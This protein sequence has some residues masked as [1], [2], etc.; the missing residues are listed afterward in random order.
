[1]AVCLRTGMGATGNTA[2]FPTVV[3]HWPRVEAILAQARNT[4]L[5]SRVVRAPH[6]KLSLLCTHSFPCTRTRV[7]LRGV[8]M[9]IDL[10]AAVRMTRSRFSTRLAKCACELSDFLAEQTRLLL[11]V[12][13]RSLRCSQFWEANVVAS[14]AVPSVARLGR[15]VLLVLRGVPLAPPGP[16]RL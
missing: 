6:S 8:R 3:T 4:L 13:R 15:D 14:L 16:R 1:M 2:F 5:L 7:A 9:H 10:V 12:A 11:L